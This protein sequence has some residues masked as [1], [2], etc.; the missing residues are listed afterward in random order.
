MRSTISGALMLSGRT[1]SRP[2]ACAASVTGVGDARPARPRGR[3]GWEITS[4][5]S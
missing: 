1:A 4:A 2:S 5:T 3:S